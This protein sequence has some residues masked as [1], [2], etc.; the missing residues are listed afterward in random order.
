[1]RSSRP[2]G[3][4]LEI[5]RQWPPVRES[6]TTFAVCLVRRRQNLNLTAKAE[7][8]ADRGLTR[9]E[10][11]ALRRARNASGHEKNRQALDRPWAWPDPTVRERSENA[12]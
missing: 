2:G 5:N 9:G 7:Q 12:V 11:S 3:F 10:T 1:M 4:P 8:G 6:Y